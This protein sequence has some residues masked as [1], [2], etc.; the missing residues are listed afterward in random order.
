MNKH[1]RT[2]FYK[3]VSANVAKL[4]ITNQKLKWSC[5]Q[6]F[7]DPFDHNFTFLD[8]ESESFGDIFFSEFERLVFDSDD[9]IDV[10]SENGKL[11]NTFRLS[12]DKLPREHFR[13]TL[14]KVRDSFIKTGKEAL[15]LME[16]QFDEFVAKSRVLC[17]TEKNDNLL[18]WA[19]YGPS[20]TGAVLRLNVL[21]GSDLS[22]AK[23][24]KY[25]S[26]FPLIA[27]EA[28]WVSKLL[29]L[30]SFD[31]WERYF[32][33]I[34]T[35]SEDWLYEDEWRLSLY[36]DKNDPYGDEYKTYPQKV[37]GAIYLGLRMSDKD[38][39]NIIDLAAK[40][41]PHMEIWEVV[42]VNDAYKLEFNRMQ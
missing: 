38:K 29:C 36:D 23:K 10:S 30:V 32:N 39:S 19:H 18:M 37:F 31:D 20:H 13:K 34:C 22:L 15:V 25:S 21:E 26:S 11:I 6:S 33:A 41:L 42:I 16:S 2:H 28:E 5:P 17:L 14:M 3:Y 35:K 7:N 40:N 1:D 4:I 27:N 24:V 8:I 9:E 12:R